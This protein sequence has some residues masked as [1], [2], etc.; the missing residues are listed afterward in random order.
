MST[1]KGCAEFLFDSANAESIATHGLPGAMAVSEDAPTV[2]VPEFPP[3][4]L[5]CPHGVRF[6]AYP[7]ARR[8]KALRVLNQGV[9]D[10]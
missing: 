7:N 2:A 6:Y 3:V 4:I 5:R 10:E 9:S 1:H 8:I